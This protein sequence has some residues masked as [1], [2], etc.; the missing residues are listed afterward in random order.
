MKSNVA[1][2]SL[3]IK[4]ALAVAAVATFVGCAT[5]A[6]AD[7]FTTYTV[8][9][10]YNNGGG[11]I[12]GTFTVDATVAATAPGGTLDLTAINLVQTGSGGINSFNF[13]DTG[14]GE[15]GVV[16]SDTLDQ[17]PSF[18]DLN[19]NDGGNDLTLGFDID[20][21][22][23]ATTGFGHSTVETEFSGAPIFVVSGTITEGTG[24][25]AAVPEPSTWAMMILGFFG[26]GF[27]AYRR[28]QNGPALRLA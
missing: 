4:S 11:T 2:G 26:I 13:T 21:G 3:T 14:V 22:A 16:V 1:W 18:Y 9:A 6:K 15:Q 12:T 23:L 24:I 7:V 5:A 28:K 25:T 27:M 8:D 20:G 17:P 10:S 19:I